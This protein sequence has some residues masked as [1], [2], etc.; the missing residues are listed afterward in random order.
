MSAKV[1][2]YVAHRRRLGYDLRVTARELHRFASYADSVGHHGP[3]TTELA[4]RWARLA[5][6]CT[7]LYQARRIEM[8]RPFAK[9]LAAFEPGTQI[10]S[11]GVL[12][13]AHRRTQPHIYAP[14]EVIQLM[15]AAEKLSPSGGLRPITYR[16]LLGL[17]ASTGLRVCEALKLERGDVD[18]IHHLLSVRQTKFHKSRLVPLHE[19]ATRALSAYA[20]ARDA[21][22]PQPR[23]DRFLL[24]E[25]GT[26]L[27][28]SVVH[29]TF[30][31][32]RASVN[33]GCSNGKPS[34]LYDLRHTFA[35]QRLLQWYREGIDVQH[36]IL[37]LSTYM[38]HVR[39]SDTYWY[40][41]GIPELLAIA[42]QRFE[43][44]SD[45]RQGGSV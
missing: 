6:D 8:I 34:R 16:T 27:L 5:A 44:L 11:R 38:G 23:S 28:P 45:R 15:D 41:S 30:Q 1:D 7:P 17:L 9:Y 39:A 29:Y 42:A 21:Y 40:L 26:A 35:C 37:H 36:A 32:L 4:L 33:C 31:K 18:L 19:S 10:P 20:L 25:R 2:E 22:R 12:G 24:S 13:P 43:R 3:L 14:Q